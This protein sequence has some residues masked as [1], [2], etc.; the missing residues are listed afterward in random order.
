MRNEQDLLKRFLALRERVHSLFEETV[1]PVQLVSDA[2][3]NSTWSPPVDLYETEKEF[4][5]LAELPG[6]E[7]GDLDLQIVDRMIVLKGQR[8][9][10]RDVSGQKYHRLERPVGRFERRFELPEP[11]D[12]PS[13]KAKMVDGVLTVAIPKKS[14]RRSSIK[15]EVNKKR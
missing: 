13:I 10:A 4:V 7:K 14:T 5:L 3:L 9:F 1:S 12:A 15:V 8:H 6:I 11:V 2:D